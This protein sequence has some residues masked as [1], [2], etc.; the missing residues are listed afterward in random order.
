MPVIRA[1]SGAP[2]RSST[3]PTRREAELEAER[4]VVADLVPADRARRGDRRVAATRRRPPGPCAGLAQL[5]GDRSRRRAAAGRMMK[6]GMPG[7]RPRK[8]RM[9]G[10]RQSRRAAEPN[11]LVIWPGQVERRG[12]AGDDRG[13]GDRQQQRRHLRDQRVADREQ[14]IGRGGVAERQ[15]VAE[16]AEDQAADDVDDQDQHAG[17]RRRPSRTWRR[18]PSSRRNR[19]RS[20]LPGGGP[21][22]PRG[23]AGRR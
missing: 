16:R 2:L 23:S 1:I 10:D 21:W 15:A 22:L 12:D 13:G 20:R 4:G 18:R 19:P 9:R 8:S 17:D 6:C 14:D 7:S 11:W 3:R 5:P